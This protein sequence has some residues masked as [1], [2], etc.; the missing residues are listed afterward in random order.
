[1]NAGTG[2]ILGG[3]I[4]RLTRWAANHDCWLVCGRILEPTSSKHGLEWAQHHLALTGEIPRDKMNQ[5]M[6]LDPGKGASE[7]VWKAKIKEA[8]ELAVYLGTLLS[9]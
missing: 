6:K 7:E 4:D 2:G 5:I 1:M 9:R 8:D 3:S